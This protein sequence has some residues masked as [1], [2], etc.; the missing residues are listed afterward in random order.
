MLMA[1]TSNRSPLDCPLSYR[2]KAHAHQSD[3][4]MLRSMPLSI[5]LVV[6]ILGERGSA[7]R[8]NVLSE[9]LSENMRAGFLTNDRSNSRTPGEETLSTALRQ[10][11]GASRLLL[12]TRARRGFASQES[13]KR[14]HR[15]MMAEA[16]EALDRMQRWVHRSAF[17]TGGTH[18]CAPL[19]SIERACEK[20]KDDCDGTPWEPTDL[21][22]CSIVHDTAEELCAGAARLQDVMLQGSCLNDPSC[23]DK[24]RCSGVVKLKNRFASPQD[25]YA[26]IMLNVLLQSRRFGWQVAELQLHLA[27]VVVSKDLD[28]AQAFSSHAHQIIAELQ[29]R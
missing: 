1:Q 7:R 17:L 9:E 23:I 28:I 10:Q 27:P 14:T 6:C 3:E 8:D 5:A 4:T 24:G 12:R 13:C 19:K 18:V 21:I 11:L 20:I 25:G 22:R 29:Q 16:G 2:R 15:R 26:D